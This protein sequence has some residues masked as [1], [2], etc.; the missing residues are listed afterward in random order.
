MSKKK[1]DDPTTRINGN[2]SAEDEA[3]VRPGRRLPPVET[4]F[5]PGN[6]GRPKG[7][8]NKLGEAFLADLYADWQKHGVQV[9][10]K[11]R[12]KRPADYLKV[13]ASILPRDLHITV[14]EYEELSDDDLMNKIKQMERKVRPLLESVPI[15]DDEVKH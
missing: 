10:A 9:L 6:P 1:L 11:V 5:Q 15:N 12:A 2:D 13:V 4:R 7:S 14:S 8:R 3:P